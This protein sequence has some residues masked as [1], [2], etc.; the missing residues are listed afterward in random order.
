MAHSFD[1]PAQ[2]TGSLTSADMPQTQSLPRKLCFSV[3]FLNSG[4]G[5]SLDEATLH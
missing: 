1:S 5:F 4:P 3:M 2:S